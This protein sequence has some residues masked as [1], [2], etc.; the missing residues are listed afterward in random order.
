[1]HADEGELA[2]LQA[3]ILDRNRSKAGVQMKFL[4]DLESKYSEPKG[5][6]KSKG[7]GRRLEEPSDEEFE[8]I[9]QSLAKKKKT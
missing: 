8:R 1:M 6:K 2:K 3:S 9:Q 7:S 5:A 4:S